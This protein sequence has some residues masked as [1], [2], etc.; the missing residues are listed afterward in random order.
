MKL[1]NKINGS[2]INVPAEHGAMLLKQRV[3]KEVVIEKKKEEPVVI[4]QV[5]KK[6]PGR[7]R[8]E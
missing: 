7:P 4:E 2:V 3:W 6:G 1:E 8:K 5:I